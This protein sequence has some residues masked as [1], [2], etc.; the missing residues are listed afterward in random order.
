M[1][2]S[3]VGAV[4]AMTEDLWTQL[5]QQLFTP[6]R[7]NDPC[8]ATG[9]EIKEEKANCSSPAETRGLD[10]G[11]ESKRH[12]ISTAQIVES[13]ALCVGMPGAGK[14]SLLNIYLN[15][16]S[17]AIPKPTVALEYMFARRSSAANTPKV[18][19]IHQ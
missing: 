12:R 17:D 8:G 3:T 7:A 11:G 9:T 13:S 16:N 18:S 6:V 19:N 15:P 2:R 10:T 14:S 4:Q 5:T 1:P